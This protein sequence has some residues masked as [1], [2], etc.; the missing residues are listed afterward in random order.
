LDNGD[1]NYNQVQKPAI[2]DK[3]MA[4][5]K[6][7]QLTGTVLLLV[8]FRI[9]GNLRFLSHSEML[10]LFRRGCAR[11]GLNIRFSGGF[12]PQPKL[13]LPLPRPVGVESDDELLVI[14]LS[15]S[16]LALDIKKVIGKLSVQMPEGIELFSA[17]ISEVK[18]PPHP[19]MVI[20]RL[21][22]P[23]GAGE[24]LKAEID[25]LLAA[26]H[27]EIRR[28]IDETGR[29]RNIDVRPFL[30]SLQ[31]NEQGIIAEC[32]VSSA[33]TIRVSEITELLGLDTHKLTGPVRR[34]KIRWQNN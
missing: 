7:A 17:E 8:K 3:A 12:N 31:L 27:I 21:S 20:Y 5:M 16:A 29:T 18:K 34:Q 6:T 2:P 9:Y 11:A 1:F 15:G 32:T 24:K 23:Q 30:E 28:R 13:S 33:G 4:D 25:R 10:R 26:E 14:L 19:A 22:L